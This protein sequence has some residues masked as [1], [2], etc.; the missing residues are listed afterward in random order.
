MSDSIIPQETIESKIYFIRNKKVMLDRDLAQLYRVETKV[1]NQ[2]VTRNIKRFPE[3]FMFKLTWNETK[4]LRSHFVTLKR[5]E[6]IKYQPRVFTEQGVAMLSSVLRSERAI[7]VNIQIMRAF[8]K[9][10][11]MLITHKD[12]RKKIEEME[13][14]YDEQFKIVFT[15]IKKLLSPPD[16][17]E[18]PIGFK[19]DQ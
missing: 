10:R 14:K 16:K 9:L 6:H 17:P 5:G 18:K 3:D 19:K 2:A 12:L 1:L 15:A 13:M 11:E 8:I 4:L 7:K